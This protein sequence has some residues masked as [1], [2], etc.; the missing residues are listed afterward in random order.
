MK[1]KSFISSIITF[2]ISSIVAGFILYINLDISTLLNENPLG[3]GF[4][5][6]IYI[7]LMIILS[8]I[9]IGTNISCSVSSGIC[10]SST[11]KAIKI[12]SIVLFILSIGLLILNGFN[13]AE[14][15]RVI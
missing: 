9:A 15:I 11:N 2:L 14:F 4:S 10:I 7:P 8:L 5:M 3:F 12:I 1:I 6:V 13:I